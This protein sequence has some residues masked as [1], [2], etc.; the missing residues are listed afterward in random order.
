MCNMR[1]KR[2][3]DVTEL[4]ECTSV[5]IKDVEIICAGTTEY[6]ISVRHRNNEYEG[7]AKEYDICFIF[8][9]NI[10]VIPFYT[11]PQVDIFATDSEGGY[12]GTIGQM[13][14]L[15]S[16]APICYISKDKRCYIVAENGTGFLK[17]ATSWRDNLKDYEGVVFYDS[18]DAAM[19]EREF[20]NME[21]FKAEE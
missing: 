3:L 8:D 10:P 5:W 2:Y 18:K 19:L 15:E 1:K 12:L 21:E 17:N 20:I 4:K 7:Y 9:D 16:E 6:S 11:I 13:S 14:D